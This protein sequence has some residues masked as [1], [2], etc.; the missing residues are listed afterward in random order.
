MNLFDVYSQYDIEPISGKGS[1]VYDA[2]GTEYL[3]FYGGHAVISV[4]HTHPVYVSKL[5][6]Q[7]DKIGFYSNAVLNS[8]QQE[9]A[10]KLES[11]S[12]VSD[13]A[14]F[15]CSTGAEANENALKLA[16]FH[17]GRTKIVALEN[18]FHGRTSAAVRATHNY[19]IQAP[20][21][22]GYDISYVKMNDVGAMESELA[23]GEVCA[24]IIEAIQGIG[25]CYTCDTEYL[26][27]VSELCQTNGTVL[28]MDEVQAG[29]A[30][31]GKFFSFQNANIRPHIITMAKGMGNG[32][33][34]A[35]VLIDEQTFTAKKGML[36]TT[37]GGNHLACAA[38]IA[39]LEII[40]QENL[41]QHAQD[42]GQYFKAEL[43]SKL[44]NE[45]EVLGNGL[46][47]GVKFN[48][49]SAAIRKEMLYQEKIF[50]GSSGN[51]NIMRILPPLNI[52]KEQVDYFISKLSKV[53]E[54]VQI[55]V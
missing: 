38:G 25:G 48:F 17:T 3:D 43:E 51:A 6:D 54:S 2:E 29:Y 27:K 50:T 24:V 10:D 41:I 16:S 39:V 4:G 53:F 40:E 7:L 12:G 52:K 42:L 26:E 8:L 18:G 23:G 19:A 49:S 47:I 11:V 31:S 15:Y 35:G 46:M 36:G 1:Y 5:K 20:I 34:I 28:I 45:V 44:G 32:F 22:Q 14:L 30:R 9:L 33:P 21:N 37:F 13:Y 55:D